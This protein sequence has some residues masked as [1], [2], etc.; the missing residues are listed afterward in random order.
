LLQQSLSSFRNQNRSHTIDVAGVVINNPFY[1]GGNDGGPE[2]LEAMREI[3]AEAAKNGWRIYRHQIMHS[4]GFPKLMRG[5]NTYLGNA[6]FFYTFADEF[7]QS[8]GV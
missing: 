8:I 5:N 2:K 3:G 6:E 1:N 7:F 4:R